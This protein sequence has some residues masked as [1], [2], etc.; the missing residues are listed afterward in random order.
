[1]VGP[2]DMFLAMAAHATG[3]QDLATRHADS[4]LQQCADWDAPL[5]ADWVRRERERFGI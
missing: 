2:L 1:V 3:Q 5:A 4:A